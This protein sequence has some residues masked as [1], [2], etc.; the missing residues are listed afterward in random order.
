M[1]M[2][3]WCESLFE[4][5]WDEFWSTAWTWAR[6]TIRRCNRRRCRWICL[7]CNR[8]LCWIVAVLVAILAFILALIMTIVAVIVCAICYILCVLLCLLGI[9]FGNTDPESCIEA[10]CQGLPRQSDETPPVD[11]QKPGEPG[12][13]GGVDPGGA[14]AGGGVVRGSQAFMVESAAQLQALN[15]WRH[16]LGGPTHLVL[17]LEGM[18]DKEAKHWQTLINHQ[19]SACGCTEGAIFMIVGVAAYALWL[20]AS[21]AVHPP[22][23]RS[24]LITGLVVVLA[25]GL[26]GKGFGVFRA[27]RRLSYLVRQ[28]E[29]TVA[30]RK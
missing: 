22:L 29:T 8:W 17:K 3:G 28:L 16:V 10:W 23:Q 13:P 25:A 26:V 11:P 5:I 14:L 12:P 6:D 7:C 21:S 2:C 19:L 18:N 1:S 15:T 24:T 9:L 20:A 30:G 4:W 27:R